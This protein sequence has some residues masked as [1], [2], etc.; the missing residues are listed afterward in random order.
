MAKQILEIAAKVTGVETAVGQMAALTRKIDAMQTG[1]DFSSFGAATFTGGF[2][3]QSMVPI[4]RAAKQAGEKTSQGF[5]EGLK[6]D[7]GKSSTMGQM[8]KLM[9]G[10]GA[11]Y[12]LSQ[13]TMMVDKGADAWLKYIKGTEGAAEALQGFAKELPVIGSLATAMEKIATYGTGIDQISAD[14]AR[15]DR[16]TAVMAKTLASSKQSRSIHEG[17]MRGIVGENPADAQARQLA[18]QY[19]D[20]MATASSDY[21]AEQTILRTEARKDV[22]ESVWSNSMLR[23]VTGQAT[24]GFMGLGSAWVGPDSSGD[25][26]ATAEKIRSLASTKLAREREAAEFLALENAAVRTKSESDF[27][28]MMHEEEQKRESAAR[29]YYRLAAEWDARKL[30][31][32]RQMG[33]TFASPFVDMFRAPTGLEREASHLRILKGREGERAAAMGRNAE[34]YQYAPMQESRF[35]TGVGMRDLGPQ[36]PVVAKLGEV[37]TINESVRDA[38]EASSKAIVEGMRT[39]LQGMFSGDGSATSGEPVSVLGN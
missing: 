18:E 37:V 7:F 25:N 31:S 26:A 1:G 21:A 13:A 20:R 19:R 10:G 12:A 33:S 11:I 36:E 29:D 39:V 8:L 34:P 6:E 16:W 9:R 22:R 14:A 28:L 5:M 30:E 15:Q 3:P 17:T 4:V 27:G 32:L 2:S 23:L 35:L 38:V 24:K